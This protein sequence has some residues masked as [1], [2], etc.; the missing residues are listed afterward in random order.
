[1]MRRIISAI[2]ILIL[3]PMALDDLTRAQAAFSFAGK[4]KLTLNFGEG[5]PTFT[6]EIEAKTSR[7]DLIHQGGGTVTGPLELGPLA[8]INGLSWRHVVDSG[9]NVVGVSL[10]FEIFS[11]RTPVTVLVRGTPGDKIEGEAIII[12]QTAD[13][14]SPSF[15]PKIGYNISRDPFELERL[16]ATGSE[17]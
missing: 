14:S 10:T 11:A 5:A 1:M 15:D 3:V 8:R 17:E 2:A 4:W 13:P 7:E 9:G 6:Y 16:S 12:E